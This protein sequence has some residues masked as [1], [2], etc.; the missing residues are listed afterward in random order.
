[1]FE[2]RL[3]QGAMLKKITEAMK[4]LVTEAN[5]DC[6]ST[7]ISLQAMDS[8]HVSLVALLLRSDGFD[9]FRCDRNISLGIN[10]GSMG[11]VLKCCNND[12]IVTLKADDNGD[13]MTFMF[14]NQ[15][16]DRISDFELKLM[17]IDSEHLG[18]PETDYKSMIKMPA[19]EF[20]R[21]C[22]DLQILG[23]TVTIAIGKD[24]V[25]FSVS[26]EMG[27]GNMTIRQNTSVDTKEEEQVQIEMEEPVTLNFALRYLN[28]FT[29]ATPLSGSVTLQL[30]KDVPLVVEYKMEDLGH[31]RFYLA[32]KIEDEA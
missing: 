1:M 20:Q 28:F 2:A 7:G 13:S 16:Q 11:K 26:G 5:F 18:I 17:D 15:S 6:S 21:I 14:E 31:M 27:S 23:D 24:G 29:K 25:K 12:D 3:T 10:L 19:S 8:S 4:D 30:S 32:P 9:H 22:R